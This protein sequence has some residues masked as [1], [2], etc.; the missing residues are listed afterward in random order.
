VR[1]AQLSRP[2]RTFILAVYA[3]TALVLGT[4]AAVQPTAEWRWEPFLVLTVAA[5]IAHSFPV[6]T[7]TKQAFHV[8]LPFFVAA[9][10]LLAPLQVA[11]L[12]LIVNGAE[13]WRR[14]RARSWYTQ[15]FNASSYVLVGAT[16]QSVLGL[17]GMGVTSAAALSQPGIV[18]ATAAIVATY[19]VVNRALIGTAIWL[20]H[21]IPPR[22]QTITDRESVGT[23]AVLLALGLPMALLMQA[24]PWMLILGAA[25]LLLIHRALD[26]PNVRAQ[27]RQDDLTKLFTQSYLSEVCS[28]EIAR[29]HRFQRPIALLAIDIDHLGRVNAAHGQQTGDAIIQ[30]TARLIDQVTRNYDVAARVAG[31]QFALLLPE[32][33]RVAAVAVGERLRRLVSEHRFEVVSSLDPLSVTASIGVAVTDVQGDRADQLFAIADRALARAKRDGRNRLAAADGADV[34]ATV[35]T[36]TSATDPDTQTSDVSTPIRAAAHSGNDWPPRW[37]GDP[38]IASR[39]FAICVTAVGALVVL[40]FASAMAE[41]DREIL[42][43]MAAL[44]VLAEARPLELPERSSYSL[45]NVPIMAAG[46]LLGPVGAVVV[47]PLSALMRGVSRRIVWYKVGFNAGNYIL[48][49]AGAAMLFEVA[50]VTP[51]PENLPVLLPLAGAAGLVYFL[52]TATTALA[53]GTEMRISPIAI[54]AGQ[55]RWFWWQYVVLAV[56]ALLLALAYRAFGLIGAAAFVVPPLMMRY[57]AKQYVDKTL[58]HVRQLRGLNEQ[59]QA[60]I[61][62][63]TAAEEANARLA[64]E[65]ARAAAL[66]ELSRLKSEFIS[67]ASHELRTPMATVLGFSELLLDEVDPADPRHQYVSVIHQD[68]IQLSTLVNNLL[69]ISRIETGRLAVELEP[70]DL[71]AVLRPLVTMLS[72]PAPRHDLVV[73]LDPAARWVLADAAKLNQILMNLV[74]NAI[75][76]SPGGGDVIVRSAPMSDGRVQLSVTDQGMGI[77]E[78]HLEQIFERFYRVDSSETRAIPGTGLGLYIVRHL[79]ELHGGAI[80]AESGNGRGSTFRFTL[81]AAVPPPVVPSQSPAGAVVAT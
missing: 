58:E 1:F 16:A 11:A 41:L 17:T 81:S 63:R 18:G 51:Q 6:A 43:L 67:V 80:V 56:M 19:L 8:S 78:E 64:S 47:A 70:V 23:E 30:G 9:I 29:A 75:K 48:F 66:E 2:A 26:L 73:E 33:D 74:G 34:T 59:L 27:S 55:Y 68:A 32:T 72:A 79:V 76:Y 7:P 31:G 49:A 20:A 61:A 13:W 46:I 69:D 53:V 45:A 10:L 60:E 37:V 4:L 62:Q 25:P 12:M 14:R 22:R 42:L 57:V 77:P 5:T 15:L 3:A 35:A 44:I 36:P 39:A 40:A 52:H 28:R 38:R 71:E 24:G 54:W 65:A 21:G 50:D